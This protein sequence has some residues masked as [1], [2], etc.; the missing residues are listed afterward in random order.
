MFHKLPH[1]PQATTTEQHETEGSL[2]K[3]LRRL[4]CTPYIPQATTYSTSYHAQIVTF[5]SFVAIPGICREICR[6][7]YRAGNPQIVTF[8]FFFAIPE[9][10]REMCRRYTGNPKSSHFFPFGGRYAVSRHIYGMTIE[11]H[12]V[13]S[14]SY[15]TFHKLPQLSCMRQ[16]SHFR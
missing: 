13:C 16:G 14:T 11:L 7:I 15:H 9:I 8:L 2:K 6:E 4:S 5:L 3:H 10:C 12:T 1:T